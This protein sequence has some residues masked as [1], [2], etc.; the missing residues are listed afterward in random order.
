MKTNKPKE[1]WIIPMDLMPVIT[2]ND[3]LSKREYMR[4][5]R[6]INLFIEGH[7]CKNCKEHYKLT[8]I[9]FDKFLQML[10]DKELINKKEKTND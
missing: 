2:K 5:K 10:K 6:L 3:Y 9:E 4:I 7:L 8:F 1:N